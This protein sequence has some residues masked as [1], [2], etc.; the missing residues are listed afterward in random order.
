[1]KRVQIHYFS[2]TGN[3]ERATGIIAERF[4][5]AGVS[6]S[7]RVIGTAAPV[8]DPEA[9]ADLFAFPALGFAAP[10]MV[11][12]YIRRL[13]KAAGRT[14]YVLCVN[15]G[16]PMQALD[17]AER[18]LKRRGY[19]VAATA[20]AAYPVNWTQ[21]VNPM[22]EAAARTVLDKGDETVRILAGDLLDG[23]S[24]YH[25]TGF[26]T[27]LWSGTVA[28]FFGALG[29]R[30]LGKAFIADQRC[31]GCGLCAEICPAG[32]I[33]L[34]GKAGMPRWGANCE[35]CNRCINL[36]PQRAIQ[37]SPLRF[38]IGI[39]V[40]ALIMA[41]SIAAGIRAGAAISGS[42][43]RFISVPG[44]IAAAIAV[45]AALS[46]LQLSAADLLL[47]PLQTRFPASFR[48]S[49]TTDF[50]RYK[51]PGFVPARREKA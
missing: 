32:T 28:F 24:R 27:R 22:D 11:K 2:S 25:H 20:S 51:A 19:R 49:P 17:Q 36:C 45:F 47:S 41:A 1:M 34:G 48:K 42:V 13:P 29:R 3:T 18:M 14:A 31:T 33:R 46:A 44:G 5:A 7:R 6:V 50:R 8:P 30:M 12:R 4:E 16:G 10:V 38:K 43:S 23:K 37:H 15:A 9:D 21:I 35:N 39:A 40:Q 26:G